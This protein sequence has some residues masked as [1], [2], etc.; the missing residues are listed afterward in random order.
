MDGDFLTSARQQTERSTPEIKAAA[1]MR[2]ARVETRTA[3]ADARANFARGLNMARQGGDEILLQ[4]SRHLAA[5]VAPDLL[6]QIRTR[7]LGPFDSLNG[8][9]CRI[10]IEH[11]HA[12][13]AAPY[14]MAQGPR[15]F[16]L[17]ALPMVMQHVSDAA[18]RLALMRRAVEVWRFSPGTFQN[19]FLHTFQAQWPDL[20]EQEARDTLR[21]LIHAIR[22]GPEIDAHGGC[23]HDGSVPNMGREGHFF[24]LLGP[25]RELDAPLAESL[26][27]EYPKLA[28][29][30]RRYP[31]GVDSF[32]EE[33]RSRVSPG[34]QRGYIIAGSAQDIAFGR[35]LIHAQEDGDFVPAMEHAFENYRKDTAP[36]NPNG[37][38]VDAWPSSAAYRSTLYRAGAQL[39]RD[40]AALLDQIPSPDLRLFAQIELAAALAGLPELTTPQVFR[41]KRLYA[42]P[43][44]EAEPVTGDAPTGPTRPPRIRCPKCN[45]TP[46]AEDRWQCHCRH[47]WNTFDT[48][49]VCPGCL[50]QWKITMCLNCQQWSPH[51]DWYTQS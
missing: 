48:G 41:P 32:I 12:G 19:E 23:E 8:I 20:P 35:S 4:H 51:S 31:N 39:G 44:R 45:W 9:L 10:M 16:P 33:I 30:T 3:P 47:V 42:G 22:E 38:P 46:R 15:A 25:L 50:Y 28:A 27:A 18:T 7:W 21:D 37:A 14:V 13:A 26:I 43:V 17:M 2:I 49:G 11:G 6:P 29:A 5:A 40:A 36:A 34:P 1:L 24:Q